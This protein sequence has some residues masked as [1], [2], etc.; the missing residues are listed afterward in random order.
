MKLKTTL[1]KKDL[2]EIIRLGIE[3]KYGEQYRAKEVRL[4]ASASHD[5]HDRPTGGHDISC[6]VELELVDMMHGR[7][8]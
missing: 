5:Y 6:E 8:C 7:P 2:I 4:T 3:M 1:D